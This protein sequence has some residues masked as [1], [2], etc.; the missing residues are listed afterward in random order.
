MTLSSSPSRNRAIWE[1]ALECALRREN[2]RCPEQYSAEC[3]CRY[4]VAQYGNFSEPDLR[5]YILQA[6]KEACYQA[7]KNRDWWL[8][9]AA[10]IAVVIGIAIWWNDNNK[11]VDESTRQLIE[12]R[13]GN[14]QTSSYTV[15]APAGQVSSTVNSKGILTKDVTSTLDRVAT[16]LR[17][18]A[19]VNKDGLTNCIDAAVLFYQYYPDKNKV[20]IEL[21]V[22][23]ATAMNHLFNCVLIDGSW[24]AIEPQAY[25]HN[26]QPVR[27]K[28][29]WGD[30]YDRQYNRDVTSDYLKYVR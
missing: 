30:R 18:N 15:P 27:M 7:I 11:R 25:W 6:D 9:V 13:H 23:N 19:D 20:C 24:V 12:R 21:N 4:N 3:D 2:G 5:L 1:C 22:N 8:G 16:R 10:F 17:Q 14:S 29:F 28:N 26:K